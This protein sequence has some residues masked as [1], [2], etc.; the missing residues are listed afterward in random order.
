VDVIARAAFRL[1]LQTFPARFRRAHGDEMCDAFARALG[2][3]TVAG[4]V[5]YTL[6]A[7]ADAVGQ[8]WRERTR[9]GVPRGHGAEDT[10]RGGRGPMLVGTMND[11]RIAARSLRRAPG[12]TLAATIVLALGIGAN[13]TVFSALERAVLAPS[14]YPAA[15]RLVIVDHTWRRR[16]GGAPENFPWSWPKFRSFQ[17]A[18]PGAIAAAAGYASR[19]V[20]VT[21]PGTPTRES[22]E[23]VTSGYFPVL[24]RNPVLGRAFTVS[25][26]EPGITPIAV[27]S[28]GFWRSRLGGDPGAVGTSITLNG[29]RVEVV[30]VAP[31]GFSGLSG[32]AEL[33]IPM[34][35]AASFFSPVLLRGRE[36]HWFRV[37]GRLSEGATLAEARDQVTA[38]GRAI[39][40]EVPPQD[41]EDVYGAGLRSFDDV[42]VNEDARAAVFLL[43]AAAGLVLLVACANLSGLLLARSR[44]LA[45]DEAVR[46]AVGASRWRLVRASLVES[47]LLAGLG[48]LAGLGLS[49]WGVRA[50][51]AAWPSQFTSSGGGELR[52]MDPSSLA[53]DSRVLGF[54]LLVTALT[55]TL[56]GVVPALRASQADVAGRLREGSGA[57]RPVR[58]ALGLDGRA[59]LVGAQVAL[60]LVL[61]V[62]AGLVGGSVLR[63]LDVDEGFDTRA[64][65]TFSY[66][67]PATSASADDPNAFHAAFRDRV[68]S[69]PG[70]TGVTSGCPPLEGY[71]WT[72]LVRAIEGAPEI[73]QGE[74]PQVAV[75]MVG[76]RT[77]AT[78]GIP[79][80]RGRELDERDGT[81]RVPAVVISRQAAESLF[82]G[83]DPLG[84]RIQLGVGADDKDDL[85]EI[86]GVVGDV[87]YR[88]PDEEILPQAYYSW[89]DYPER[90][91]TMMVRTAGDPLA[92][93][94]AIR[95]ELGTMDRTLA[96]YGVSTMD[97]AMARSMGDRSVVLV[98]LALFAGVTLLLAAT[99]TW[100]IVA[101]QIADRRRELGLRMALGAGRSSVLGMVLRQATRTAGL[102]LVV[103]LAGAW[104]GSQLLDT[105]LFQTRPTDPLAY[106]VAATLLL[107]V[108]L[109][110]SW[111]PARRA[112]RVAPVEA[113]RAD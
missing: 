85:A 50:M 12:F 78:L 77:F 2:A 44:R 92:S 59:A 90:A 6:H 53:L 110:A 87:L 109:T 48:G 75:N 16:D 105:F 107:G 65:L 80:L 56:F 42:R 100:G 31:A 37:V 46:R 58:R 1:A 69:L 76:D 26:D 89:R 88:G 67:I 9:R 113:L 63:L 94:P 51:A 103:G 17:E 55:A 64:L 108:V 91:V 101:Y 3:R 20:T 93:L 54:A 33:W 18:R 39:G 96:I 19:S 4:R 43:A 10:E 15:D 38:L 84:R 14:G 95:A 49:A 40:E 112:T 99:G 34:A 45:R 35:A 13:T 79:L 111:L 47:F 23:L 66:A 52:V 28:H 97:Q 11:I 106:G 81:D 72:T 57:T 36:A 61:L 5:A 25:E 82:P 74:G 83:Q 68:A 104:A 7:C 62:G 73:P 30:G 21:E 71:C 22:I 8:G 24:G 98:L 32:R 41:P 86:V 29:T 70:V 60:A 102:G 27:V